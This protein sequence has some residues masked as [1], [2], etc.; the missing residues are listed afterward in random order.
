MKRFLP[1]LFTATLLTIAGCATDYEQMIQE[2][3]IVSPTTSK[4]LT[5]LVNKPLNNTDDIYNP[6]EGVIFLIG[7]YQLEAEDINYWYFR[8]PKP[9]VISSFDF[10]KQ[11]NGTRIY[12]GIALSKRGDNTQPVACAYTDES[13]KNKNNKIRIWRMSDD[14]QK[15]R[16][17]KW[18][19]S[20]DKV[21]PGVLPSSGSQSDSGTKTG[22][23]R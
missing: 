7:K 17:I 19:L 16:G 2:P 22:D 11:T 14:F 12:G 4:T 13:T 6:S 3:T 10:G 9:I 20:T 15:Q 5:L 8:S 21:Q 18:S 1:V 23:A